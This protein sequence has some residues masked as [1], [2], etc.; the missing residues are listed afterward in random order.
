[1]KIDLAELSRIRLESTIVIVPLS[2]PDAA[3]HEDESEVPWFGDMLDLTDTRS[4][5]SLTENDEVA[6]LSEAI[7]TLSER[8]RQVLNLR[9]RDDL[10]LKEISRELGLSESRVSQIHV[11]AQRKLRVL[12]RSRPSW[13]CGHSPYS[14]QRHYA[15]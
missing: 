15:R 4:D 5:D 14:R 9:Y 3:S 12:L 1:L 13:Q 10:M 8:E 7:E 2:E 6:H 11:G